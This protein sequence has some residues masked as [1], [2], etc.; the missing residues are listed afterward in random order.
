MPSEI[1]PT[2]IIDP[3]AKLGQDVQV[4][5]YCI[6]GPDV[7]LGDGCWL[8]HHVTLM[9]PSII[10]PRNRFWAYASIGQQTQ[11]LKYSGEPTGLE[12]GEGN[13]FREF[14]TVHRATAPGDKT[15]VG[16]HSHFLA[17]THIAH[18][19]IV[20]DHVIF[21]NNG[22]LAGHVVVE[23]HVILGGL[24]AVHQFCRIGRMAFI[25][26]CTKVTQ[27]VLPYTIVDGN[28]GRARG[29]NLVGMR[30]AEFSD[31]RI[32]AVNSAYRT[33]YRKGLNTTQAL[34]AIRAKTPCAEVEAMAAFAEA[35]QRGI[36]SA[37][38]TGAD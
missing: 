21:S 31:E 25:G 2:A 34:K 35:S 37:G 10:G 15:L 22:T 20:G 19:C 9:G 27:D 23:D 36:V 28:P 3:K 4:G 14:C 38:R 12:I 33:L 7:T 13:N 11:D 16:S 24:S 6:I 17:Y 18:D 1:H 29:L 30:R 26:G 5:P 8:Q 32:K